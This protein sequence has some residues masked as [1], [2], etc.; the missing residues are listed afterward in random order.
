MFDNPIFCALDTT[1]L[2][3][4]TALAHDLGGAVGGLKLGL[5]FFYRHGAEG[6]RR[7]AEAGLPIFLDLK[8]HDIPNT[9]AGGLRAVLPLGPAIINV[10]A[11]GGRAMLDAARHAVDD[12]DGPRPWLIG[13]TILTSLD[14]NDLR[15]VGYAD[16]AATQVDRM[17]ALCDAC[18]LDGVVC[19]PR[20][21]SGLRAAR[22]PGFRLI[23]P[24]I[25]PADVST[26]D[27]KRVMTPF[28][29]VNIGADVIVV[30]RP[31]TQAADPVATARAIA[32][33]L[34]EAA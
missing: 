23:V 6:Y 32:Q 26:G 22:R 7:I 29:A 9:V 5:E 25:R 19:S 14:D 13:V 15:E 12:F 8:L 33:S 16:R 4:T 2:D 20:E 21:I 17:A 10:H 28:D 27:Q 3:A 18:G 24:G 31:I 1:D 11:A 30:G 34:P